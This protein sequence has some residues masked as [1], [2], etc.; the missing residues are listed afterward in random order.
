[1][2]SVQNNF[3]NPVEPNESMT[4]SS[5]GVIGFDAQYWNG[6]VWVTVPGGSV[7]GNNKVWK[8]ISFSPITT[9]KIRVLINGTS[10]GWSRLVEVE[11]WTP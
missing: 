3:A 8:K 2:F 10:D 7:T 5:Y 11:A 6:S 1:M 9:T 4:F